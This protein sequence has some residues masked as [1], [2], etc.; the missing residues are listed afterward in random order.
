MQVVR[1]W[2]KRFGYRSWDHASSCWCASRSSGKEVVFWK[3]LQQQQYHMSEGLISIL[4]PCHLIFRYRYVYT[5]TY[6][7][8]ITTP[9][10]HRDCVSHTH[11]LRRM[12]LVLLINHVGTA[13]AIASERG[14]YC[15]NAILQKIH[16]TLK[17]HEECSL[18]VC[19]TK[20]K[21]VTSR[22]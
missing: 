6:P 15:V 12:K 17:W 22:G 19:V 1:V 21:G 13:A 9:I 20:K 4:S 7:T 3:E 10:I 18:D 5:L 14:V 11:T 2:K 16:K 8:N